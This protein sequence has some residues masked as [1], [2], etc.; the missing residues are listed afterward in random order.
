MMLYILPI[1]ILCGYTVSFGGPA[2]IRYAPELCGIAAS[3][4][5]VVR[6][7]RDG[8]A[9]IRFVYWVLMVLIALHF[10]FG[11]IANQVQV[12]TMII[13]G[14]LYLRTIPFFLLALA[15]V[16]GEKELKRQFL[17]ILGVALLQ[18][19]IAAYQRISNYRRALTEGYIS[20]TGDY[21]MGTLGNSA[22]LSIFLIC[23]ASTI[24]ALYARKKIGLGVTTVLLLIVLAPTMINETKATLFLIPFAVGI[25]M[26][27]AAKTNRFMHSI[28]AVF[29]LAGFL[30]IFVPTYDYFMMPRYGYSILDFMVMDGRVEGYL[31]KGAEVGTTGPVGRLDG[32]SVAFDVLSKDP[33]TMMLGLG[34][35]NVTES[36]FGQQYQ[37]EYFT[38]YGAFASTTYSKLLLEVGFVGVALVLFLIINVGLD[39]RRLYKQ[40]SA[41]GILAL[42]FLAIVPI[43]FAS[44]LYK[45]L[46]TAP[47]IGVCFWYY[48]GVIVAAS[49]MKPVAATKQAADD[50]TSETIHRVR[51]KKIP[52]YL[53]K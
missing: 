17:A 6:A 19:P 26:L 32:M 3:A 37:G 15:M 24:I 7:V 14:R 47:G 13:G 34:A 42:G 45:N 31:A 4:Y 39:A 49:Q 40:D 46:L 11:I 18:L 1:V 53:V 25:P 43:I 33:S 35:G 9:P 52:G 38:R 20:T 10:L 50:D 44:M 22:F 8:F 27:A 5:L 29:I 2:V 16:P 48:C 36:V 21:V 41:Y 12:G 23:F 28:K 51:Q 30:A